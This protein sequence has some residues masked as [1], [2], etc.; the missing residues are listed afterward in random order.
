MRL[1]VLVT[2]FIPYLMVY[3]PKI[4]FEEGNRK[5][6]R[7]KGGALIVS[8]H[9]LFMDY[10]MTMFHWFG[11]RVHCVMLEYVFG[12]SWFLKLS[13]EIIGGI[14]AKRDSKGMG[15]MDESV[16]LIKKGRLVQ[17][18]PEAKNTPDGKI[19]DFK[20]SYV[21]I[22]LR[23]DA[24][25]VPFILDGNYGFFK[26]AHAIVGKP[27]MLSDYCRS[28]DPSRE[29]IETLNAI[30]REKALELKETLDRKTKKR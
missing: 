7:I 10:P 24:P 25:V 21:L 1:F 15:F 6:N 8:N 17:I 5:T 3:K 29:E 4:Y 20:P 28:A 14:N 23:A 9:Y 19:H 18:Y 11:R 27:I 30:V 13:A 16:R 12:F 26:R 22:A 2:G